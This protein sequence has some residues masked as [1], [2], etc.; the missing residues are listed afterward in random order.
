M[1]NNTEDSE[2]RSGVRWRITAWSAAALML[3]LPWLAMQVTD[4]VVWDVVDF[5]IFGAL[6]ASVGG[7]FEL[8][9]RKT[10]DSAYRAAV[11]VALVA[12]FILIIVTLAVG[13]IGTEG[14]DANFMFGGVL[15]VGI[16]GAIMARFQPR[17]KARTMFAVATAQVLVAVIALFMGHGSAAPIWPLDLLGG[18]AFFAA[19]WLL[20]AWLFRRSERQSWGQVIG[21]I[22]KPSGGNDVREMYEATADSYAEMMDKEISLPV[23][24]DVLGRLQDRIAH[25]DGLLVDTACGSGHMLFMFRERFDDQRP[26]LGVDLSPRMVAIA[27]ER[28]GSDGRVV[29]GDMRDL[30]MVESGSAVAVL[31]FFAVHHLDADGVLEAMVDWHRALCNGGQLAVAA[32]EGTG[33]IDYGEESEIVALRYTGAELESLAEEAGFRV[34]RCEVEAVE[35]FPMDAVYLECVK[36]IILTPE[37][38]K[39]MA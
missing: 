22:M 34:T 17:G 38:P 4:Q 30:S 24:S 23:Y 35:G 19:L 37:G 20:S 16:F 27:S 25:T 5:V 26:V 14:D 8:A 13:I 36:S 7:T 10:K 6:L 9:E 31:N 32:W 2:G 33:A 18:T 28:L 21:S 11:A 39:Q 15:G 12:A 3:I 29:V 1:T